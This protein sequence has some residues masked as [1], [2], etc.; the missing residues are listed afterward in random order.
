MLLNFKVE[1]YRSFGEEQSISMIAGSVRNHTMHTIV[2]GD[3]K[4]L[5]FAAVFGANA[6]G[7]SNL[8]GAMYDSRSFILGLY[9]FNPMEY[10]RRSKDNVSK[11]TS[12]EYTISIA[13]SIFVYGFGIVLSERRIIDEWLLRV[14]GS[15]TTEI[16]SRTEEGVELFDAPPSD[17]SVARVYA[18]QAMNVGN[19][20]ILR[21]L[22]MHPFSE[23]SVFGSARKVFD[24]FDKSLRIVS[25][26]MIM[27]DNDAESRDEVAA[28]VLPAFGTGVTGL[29]FVNENLESVIP[30]EVIDRITRDV[31]KGGSGRI[32]GTNGVIR[33][34]N[35]GE[36][37]VAERLKTLHD[38]VQFDFVEESDGTKRLYDLVPI[39][40]RNEPEGVTYVVDEIDRNMHP[41]LTR[42]FVEEFLGLCHE[43]RRQLIVT[44]HESRLMDLDLLRRDEIWFVEKVRGS[45][46]ILFSL[47][48]FNERI[49][50][51]VD[52]NYLEGRYGAVP[53][54]RAVYPDLR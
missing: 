42:K 1:N 34:A 47:E 38:D 52:K 22:A 48:D 11:P 19:L 30:P 32:I 7:K 50:R 6:S 45:D 40:S 21:S 10:N 46:S 29:S 27:R 43:M 20:L 14:N 33:V 37:I 54:F 53:D 15:R 17:K 12:F 25:P 49:D 8:V 28:R 18:D 26:T 4:A 2:A 5:C 16:F 41:Q 51:K 3:R 23:D 13:D 24:W 31:S 9:P 36:K 44:T 35:D 39:L